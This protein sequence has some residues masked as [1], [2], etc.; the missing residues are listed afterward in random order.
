MR[1]MK[2]AALAVFSL[3]AFVGIVLSSLS[4]TTQPR[5]ANPGVSAM[6]QVGAIKAIAGKMIIL[7]TDAGAELSVGVDETTTMVRITPGEKDLKN[8]M[9]I[10]LGDLLPGDRIL[11]RG[12]PEEGARLLASSII[13]MK[14]SD[15]EV[16]QQRVREDWQKRGVGGLVSSLD[17]SAGIVVLSVP[18]L[19]GKRAVAV[20]T[21]KDTKI[22]RY[23][24]DSVRFDDAKP[25]TLAQIKPGDQLRA[26]GIRNSEGTELSAEEIVSGS[27]RNLAG[28]VASVNP[29]AGTLTVLDSATKKPAVV[30][31]TAES[32]MRSLPPELA[33]QLARRWTGG[34]Q[35][36]GH[37]PDDG[38]QAN[39]VVRQQNIGRG[40]ASAG[41]QQRRVDL[42][43][44]FNRLPPLTL[45]GMQKGD[46]VMLVGT[47]GDDTGAVTAIKLLDGVEP[48][49]VT[50]PGKGGENMTLSPWS[51]GSQAAEDASP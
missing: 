21:S 1:I 46:T 4:Q 40:E 12:K 11:V 44:M 19:S 29:S 43:Q 33:K 10:R 47:E 6:K 39:N 31:V 42:Q 18:A 2:I 48:L 20:H 30:K 17:Q 50:A 45:T 23:A 3:G 9:P 7:T 41:A 36:M 8:A 37:Q 26:R 13:A 51:L 16:Q 34:G 32:E 49:L 35:S 38:G 5:Q 25:G 22:L 24:P 14:R 27:F 15:L 28:P